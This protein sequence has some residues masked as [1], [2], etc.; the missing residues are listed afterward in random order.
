FFYAVPS[1]VQLG[2]LAL[3]I[4]AVALLVGLGRDPRPAPA[5]PPGPA[6]PS[7]AASLRELKKTNADLASRLEKQD[8]F[9]KVR[10][11][12][13]KDKEALQKDKEP[14]QRAVAERERP[15]AAAGTEIE[16]LKP[17]NPAPPVD[18]KLK[19]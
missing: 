7:L 1:V 17:G 9:D 3:L 14:R 16:R 13:E 2:M 8:D 4:T 12:L 6:D 15:L 19:D 10:G 18:P 5:P 11:G